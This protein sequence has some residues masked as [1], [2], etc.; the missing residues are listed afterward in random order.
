MPEAILPFERRLGAFPLA[1]RPRRVPRLGAAP[2]RRPLERRRRASTRSSPPA[3]GVFEAEVDAAAGRRLRATCVDGVAPPRP[4]QPLAARGPA[5]AARGVLDPGAFAWT[6]AGWRAARAA[7]R[8]SSTS[9]TS[10]RSPPRGRSRPPSRTCAPL[11]ELGVTA[12][13]LMPVAEFPGRHGWGYDGVY[14]SRR[15]VRLRRAARPPAARRRRARR[16]A[17]PC[18]LDVVYN[19]V[20]ASGDQALEAFGPYFTE[21]VRDAVGR[22]DQLRRRATPTPC[23]SGSLQCAEQWIRDFHVD[24]LRL[25]ADPRHRRLAAPSTSSPRSPAAST[26]PTPARS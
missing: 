3:S 19:H 26:P 14:L 7:R 5:R 20:G 1:R 25:D 24:G 2:Q 23:A 15:A 22:G 21:Q 12:I 18:I 8:W 11:R 13:E 16:R 4:V 6:D 17:S 10:A 9:C